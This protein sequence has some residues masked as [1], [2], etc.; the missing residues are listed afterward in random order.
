MLHIYICLQINY[1]YLSIL[2]TIIKQRRYQRTRPAASG[3]LNDEMVKLLLQATLQFN[4][5][6]RIVHL[7]NHIHKILDTANLTTASY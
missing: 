6:S 2:S 4:P 5:M 7:H 3:R 1:A